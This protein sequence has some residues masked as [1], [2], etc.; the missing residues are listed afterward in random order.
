MSDFQNFSPHEWNTQ[1]F[2]R[3]PPHQCFFYFFTNLKIFCRQKIFRPS[4]G[5]TPR[6]TPKKFPP[7]GRIFY[8]KKSYRPGIGSYRYSRTRYID[9][10]VEKFY[11][12]PL[13]KYNF[14]LIYRN[15][16]KWFSAQI[17]TLKS[18]ILAN[19]RLKVLRLKML[20]PAHPRLT[21]LDPDFIKIKG[22]SSKEGK[23]SK[24]FAPAADYSIKSIKKCSP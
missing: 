10:A 2:S 21:F 4:G 14:T 16:K 17:W 11:D 7:F 19:L 15:N 23:N 12:W 18:I 3:L 6:N 9:R 13:T 20:V 5:F 1:K 22:K 8:I 24:L